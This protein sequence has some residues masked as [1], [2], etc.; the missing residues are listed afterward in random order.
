MVSDCKHPGRIAR[1]AVRLSH[2]LERRSAGALVKEHPVDRDQVRTPG[3]GLHPVRV[4]DQI[5]QRVRHQASS[6][7]QSRVTSV[8]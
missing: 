5:D 2:V 3:S 7:R 6:E 4:P 8:S 1:T